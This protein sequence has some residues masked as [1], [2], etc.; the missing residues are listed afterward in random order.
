M[1]ASI[2]SLLDVIKIPNVIFNSLSIVSYSESFSCQIS[3]IFN[4]TNVERAVWSFLNGEQYIL[5]VKSNHPQFNQ[6][7]SVYAMQ[8]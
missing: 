8:T 3:G 2:V 7:S 5:Q 6:V 4:V 1:P